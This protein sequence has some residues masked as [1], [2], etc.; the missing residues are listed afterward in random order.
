M[1]ILAAASIACENVDT[2]NLQVYMGKPEESLEGY[3]YYI[4]SAI[5]KYR[6]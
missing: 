2:N 3:T 4:R 5:Y 1:Y 6:I